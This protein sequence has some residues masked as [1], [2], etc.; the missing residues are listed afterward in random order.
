MTNGVFSL[1]ETINRLA[2]IKKELAST[3][4]LKRRPYKKD[5]RVKPNTP[6]N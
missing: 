5:K 3:K 1:K 4:S 2:A 6:P